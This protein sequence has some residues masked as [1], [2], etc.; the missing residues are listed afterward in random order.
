[1]TSIENFVYI[2][3]AKLNI[4]FQNIKWTQG[5]YAVFQYCTEN[6]SYYKY[7]TETQRQA[8]QHDCLPACGPMGTDKMKKFVG[9]ENNILSYRLTRAARQVKNRLY[10]H[11]K[12]NEATRKDPFHIFPRAHIGSTVSRGHPYYFH[13]F[14]V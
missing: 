6:T 5:K 9:E 10:R 3:I 12:T 13:N 4:P 1:M 11:D 14:F 7:Q 8:T 2:P